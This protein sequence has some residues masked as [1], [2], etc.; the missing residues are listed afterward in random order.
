MAR[1]IA[2]QYRSGKVVLEFTEYPAD[3]SST[4]ILTMLAET[5]L[6]TADEAHDTSGAI[7]AG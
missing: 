1:W 7:D 2:I 5:E 3:L 6:L 4:D